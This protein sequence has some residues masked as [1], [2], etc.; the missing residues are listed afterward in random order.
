MSMIQILPNEMNKLWT[1]H[2]TFN[3]LKINTDEI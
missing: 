2:L 1:F 3:Y